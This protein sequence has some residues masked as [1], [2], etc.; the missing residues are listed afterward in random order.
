[1]YPKAESVIDRDTKQSV[2]IRLRINNQIRAFKVRLIDQHGTN[3]GVV[4]C[5]EALYKAREAGLDLVEV[6]PDTNPPVCKIMDF[7]KYLFEQKKK[8]KENQHKAPEPHEI[9]LSP[10]I[11]QSDL[12]IKAK[13][14]LEFLSGGSKVTLT[15]KLKGREAKKID[16]IEDVVKR[17]HKLVETAS[18]LE[19]KG[20]SY[21]L[22]PKH[23]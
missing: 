14:A 8:M 19:I 11:G 13:K 2:E 4:N 9:R 16:L 1:M 17:F 15:F 18:M 12:E 7:G 10:G 22:I 21:V 3:L 23:S 5:N 20:G 6:S